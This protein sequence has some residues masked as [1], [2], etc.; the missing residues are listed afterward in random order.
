MGFFVR[1]TAREA[2]S[3]VD[4]LLCATLALAV[5]LAA[6]ATAAAGAET[7]SAAGAPRGGDPATLVHGRP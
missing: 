4:L 3:G 1:V 5:L 6:L 2:R 7:A